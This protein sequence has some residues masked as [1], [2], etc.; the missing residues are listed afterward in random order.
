MNDEVNNITGKAFAGIRFGLFRSGPLSLAASQV[1]IFARIEPGAVAPDIQFHF[2]PFS[3]DSP[4]EGLHRFSAFTPAI[5]IT[6]KARA[7]I[8][9]DNR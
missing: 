8:L 3:A 9:E 2:Q 6:E 1:G 4:G 5:I 7:M